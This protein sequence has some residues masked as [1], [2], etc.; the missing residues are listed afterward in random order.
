MTQSDQKT[1][2]AG[3]RPEPA[4]VLMD[5]LNGGKGIV[6]VGDIVTPRTKD[7]ALFKGLDEWIVTKAGD[8]RWP[9]GQPLILA[10]AQGSEALIAT[11]PVRFLLTSHSELQARAQLEGIQEMVKALTPPSGLLVDEEDALAAAAREAIEQHPL[12]ITV[13]SDWTPICDWNHSSKGS[14]AE[15]KILFCFGGPAVRVIGELKAGEPSSVRLEHQDWGTP[16]TEYKL[17]DEEQAALLVYCRVF[18]FT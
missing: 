7:D 15:F 6:H 4:P 14:P 2:T 12:E 18:C 17:S 13:R 10:K 1:E 9:D 11:S 5:R 8:D 16:W 3:I